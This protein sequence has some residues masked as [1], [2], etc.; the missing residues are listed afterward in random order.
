MLNGIL[1]FKSVYNSLWGFRGNEAFFKRMKRFMVGYGFLCTALIFSSVIFGS[2]EANLSIYCLALA[3][4]V[5]TMFLI[6]ISP[7]WL[8]TLLP[9]F[10][11]TY[12][13]FIHVLLIYT[14]GSASPYA[15]IY[16]L[17]II[18]A[19]LL[20]GYAGAVVS[21]VLTLAS[22]AAM[23]LYE[24]GEAP[25]NVFY[26]YFLTDGLPF[27]IIAALLSLVAVFVAGMLKNEMENVTRIKNELETIFDTITDM[28]SIHDADYNI[29]RINKYAAER[30]GESPERL[31]GRKCYEVFRGMNEPACDCPNRETLGEKTANTVEINEPR[32]RG[33]F[34][35]AAYSIFDE[36]GERLIGSVHHMKDVTAR[37][38]AE[39]ALRKELDVTNVLHRTDVAILSISDR[40]E[41][42]NV[43]LANVSALAKVDYASIATI[44]MESNVFKTEARRFFDKVVESSASSPLDSTILKTPVFSGRSV[45]YPELKGEDLLDG[46]GEILRFGVKSLFVV[47]LIEKG[48]ASGALTLGSFKED[49]FAAE[50]RAALERYALQVALALDRTNLT[51]RIRGMFLNTVRSLSATLDAKSPWTMNHSE[52]V[53]RYSM[54]IAHELGLANILEELNLAVL[55]HD[56]GKIGISDDIL[57][58]SGALSEYEMATMMEHPVKGASILEPVKEFKNIVPV[59]RHHHEWWDGSGYPDGLSGN[60]IP[61]AARIINVADAFEAMTADRPYKK[62]RTKNEAL[63]EIRRCAGVQFDPDVANALI[64][65][66]K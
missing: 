3:G 62:R 46:D 52:S 18:L 1:S 6:F 63:E 24:S 28:L 37:R 13:L 54:A 42:L 27:F 39:D 36:D 33:I 21:I 34:E 47:P 65:A 32:L 49:G 35:V 60:M 16:F 55:L 10:I 30:L 22:Y 4:I 66:L 17:P 56:I 64:R 15:P 51:E 7:K 8:P 41:I 19:S 25:L 5:T 53:A 57:N 2:A 59:V 26:K 61:L 14:G 31:I 9:F 58:K 45:Y 40:S 44:D 12:I 48:V 38:L 11:V 50:E 20:F 43:C 23:E 29:V